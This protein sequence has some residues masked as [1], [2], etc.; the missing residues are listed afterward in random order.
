MFEEMS[1]FLLSL[2]CELEMFFLVLLVFLILFALYEILR[3]LFPQV[4]NKITK[5]RKEHWKLN[6][7]NLIV[8]LVIVF[9]FIAT[10]ALSFTFRINY[11]V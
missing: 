11:C 10:L 4:F 9:L 7:N 5:K 8:D 6:K 1:L 3:K 2:L